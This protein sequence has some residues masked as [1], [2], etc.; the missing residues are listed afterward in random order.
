MRNAFNQTLKEQLQWAASMGSARGAVLGNG[1]V[2]CSVAKSIV[3]H[4]SA[5]RVSYLFLISVIYEYS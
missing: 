1:T 2:P 3:N 4:L 5:Q